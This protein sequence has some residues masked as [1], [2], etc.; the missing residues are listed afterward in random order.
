[1]RSRFMIQDR[2]LVLRVY[3]RV[4]GLRSRVNTCGFRVLGFWVAGFGFRV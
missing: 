2:S 1:V 4:K 3:T